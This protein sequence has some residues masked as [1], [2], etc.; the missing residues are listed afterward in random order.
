MFGLLQPSSPRRSG[1][2]SA[3]ATAEAF[4]VS[5]EKARVSL[6]G[7]FFSWIAFCSWLS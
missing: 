7:T 6:R 1:R 5:S 4:E 2:A 3:P